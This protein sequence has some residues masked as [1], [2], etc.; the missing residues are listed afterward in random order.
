MT[1]DPM[2][3][4]AATTISEFLADPRYRYRRSAFPVVD[5]NSIAAGLVT[6][7]GADAV[8]EPERASTSVNDVMRPSTTCR[9]PSLTTRWPGWF[10]SCRPTPPTGHSCWKEADWSA[11]S[12]LPTSAGS[13]PL[14]PA[15]R[16]GL[17]QLLE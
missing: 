16:Q 4:P 8:A 2:T 1:L 10:P 13:H 17:V 5:G 12:L 11:P 7:K 14:T 3:V 15:D 6:L 9:R